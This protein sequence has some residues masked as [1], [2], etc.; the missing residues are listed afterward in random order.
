VLAVLSERRVVWYRQT[1]RSGRL[2]DH[3]WIP[4]VLPAQVLRL[5]TLVI[6]AVPVEPSTIAGRRLAAS[7]RRRPEETVVVNGYANA[8]AG[9]LVTPEEYDH[10]HY[11]A[12]CTMFGRWSLPAWC[13]ALHTARDAAPDSGLRPHRFTE[14][15]A[16]GPEL[17]AR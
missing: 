11:E 10:Q 17:G 2:G 4:Q 9:Y 15:D 16:L 1:L 12:A 14:A 13:T 7:V 3:P 8:Y 5:G 6:A